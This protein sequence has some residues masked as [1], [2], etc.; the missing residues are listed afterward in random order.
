MRCKMAETADI[1]TIITDLSNVLLAEK[2]SKI[3]AQ[4]PIKMQDFERKNYR[5]MHKNIH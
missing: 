5:K 4:K 2:I 3:V 1:S